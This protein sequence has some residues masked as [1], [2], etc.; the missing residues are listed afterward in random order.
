MRR[1][2]AGC[3]ALSLAA[4]ASSAS[5]AEKWETKTGRPFAARVARPPGLEY[6]AELAPKIYRGSQPRTKGYRYLKGQGIRTV[7]SLREHHDE[8]KAV[9]AAGLKFIHIP[10]DAD[11][12]GAS[13][14]PAE[15]IKAFLSAVLDPANQP[16]FFHCAVGKDR[17]GTMAAVYRMEV[18]GWS[19]EEALE[20]ME[21]FGAHGM[22]RSLTKF[23]REYKPRRK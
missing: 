10:M 23:V 9:Q 6:L 17:T 8:K 16:V 15:Q 11:L 3:L 4:P 13:P 22:F 21:A 1:F 12:N 19:P 5:P 20:E 7:L 18:D 2:L 14:P